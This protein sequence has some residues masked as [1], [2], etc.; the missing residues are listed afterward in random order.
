MLPYKLKTKLCVQVDNVTTQY[1]DCLKS[2]LLISGVRVSQVCDHPVYTLKVPK[3][4]AP[5]MFPPV[6][7]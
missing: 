6:K 3:P 1:P 7:R 5:K 4:D 2:T